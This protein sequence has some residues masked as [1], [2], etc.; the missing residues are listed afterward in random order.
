M[1]GTE[2]SVVQNIIVDAKPCP[3]PVFVD[4]IYDAVAVGKQAIIV[5]CL[6]SLPDT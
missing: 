4:S 3:I 2:K 1:N 6:E 5:H